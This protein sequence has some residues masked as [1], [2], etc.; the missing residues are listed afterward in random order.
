MQRYLNAKTLVVG[1]LV[2]IAVVAIYPD[3]LRFLPWLLIAACPLS[4]LFMHGMGGHA[5]HE[6]P[7]VAAQAAFG[8]YV[9]PMHPQV[10]STFA[11]E[12]PL[13]GMELKATTGAATKR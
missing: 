2:V 7:I 9:C 1:V 5:G 12:C 10:R 6:A 13:C 11:G 3:A 8:G 4:M